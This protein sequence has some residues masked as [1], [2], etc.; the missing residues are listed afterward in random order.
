ML[1]LTCLCLLIFS[2]VVSSDYCESYVVILGPG[3]SYQSFLDF[4]EEL[5]NDLQIKELITSSFEIGELCGFCGTFPPEVVKRLE[6]CPLVDEITIDVL[7][8]AMDTKSQPDAPRHLARLSRRRKM[9]SKKKYPYVYD[10]DTIGN[11]VSAYVLDSGVHIGHPQFQGRARRGEDFTGENC[12][13]K[14]GHGTHIAGL[15]GSETYGVAKKVQ[16][17]DVKVL[18]SN[19]RGLLSTVIAGIEFAVDHRRNN[20]C[21]GVANLPFAV[22]ENSVLDK[23]I[24]QAIWTGLVIVAA[25]GNSNSDACECSPASS[26]SAITVGAIDDFNDVISSFSNWGQCVDIFASGSYV[27]SVDMNNLYRASV[28]SGTSMASAIV[29]GVVACMLSEGIQPT[30]VKEHLLKSSTRNKIP[31]LSYLHRPYTTDKIAFNGFEASVFKLDTEPW[32][33]FSS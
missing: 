30:Y 13:D 17:I 16:L 31:E 10:D 33:E 6:C 32:D 15:I 12:G 2:R 4:D 9:A 14:N 22:K 8:Q 23:L 11:H 7:V 26:S 21:L 18:K 25:A 29:T 3:Q 28:M 24:E 20:D 19:G 27:R 5:P 1:L